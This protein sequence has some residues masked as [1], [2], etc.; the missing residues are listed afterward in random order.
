MFLCQEWDD[1]KGNAE[2]HRRRMH[3]NWKEGLV[4]II[5]NAVLNTSLLVPLYYLGMHE[6]FYYY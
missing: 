3:M 2:E 6:V 4:I 1:G 5:I